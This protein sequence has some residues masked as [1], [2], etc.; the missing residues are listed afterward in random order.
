MKSFV[1]PFHCFLLLRVVNVDNL[2]IFPL[3]STS[4]ELKIESFLIYEAIFHRKST[5]I[6]CGSLF[7]DP[8]PIQGTLLSI[9]KFALILHFISRP[10]AYP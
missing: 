6:V 4:W 3:T 9:S 10:T 2:N 7:L 8:P 1:F 5:K